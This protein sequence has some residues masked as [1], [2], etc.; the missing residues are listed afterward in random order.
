MWKTLET[1]EKSLMEMLN[2]KDYDVSEQFNEEHKPPKSPHE[3]F[4]KRSDRLETEAFYIEV[5]HQAS[6]PDYYTN[7]TCS[8]QM[9]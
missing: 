7:I 8:I 6:Q 9:D 5:S 3:Q 1:A 4:K 2:Q